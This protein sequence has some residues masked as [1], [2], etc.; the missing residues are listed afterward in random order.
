MLLDICFIDDTI[1]A[2]GDEFIDDTKMLNQAN[3]KYL[4]LKKDWHEKDVQHLVHVVLENQAE[5]NV[6]AFTHPSFYLNSLETEGYRPDIVIYD[7]EYAGGSEDSASM[8]M[9]ILEASYSVV[10]IYS[11]A[12]HKDQIDAALGDSR[13]KPY[14]KRRLAVLMKDETNSQTLLLEKAKTLYEESFAFRFGGALRHACLKALEKVLVAFGKHHKD[15]VR[16]LVREEDTI[17]SDVRAVLNEKIRNCLL[18]DKGLVSTLV[19]EG[20]LDHREANE[21][22]S[23]LCGRIFDLIN[24][25]KLDLNLFRSDPGSEEGDINES[26]ILWS[27]RLYFQPSDSV[28]RKGDI[29]QNNDLKK[30]FL[31]I[32]ADCDLARFWSKNH[33]YINLIPLF[34]IDEA[35][36]EIEHRLR[37]TRND[38]QVKRLIKNLNVDSFTGKI[39]EMVEGPFILPFVSINEELSNFI[40]FPKEIS[41]A[42]IPPPEIANGKDETDRKSRGLSYENWLNVVRIATISEPFL[43]PIVLHCISAVSGYGTPNYPPIVKKAISEGILKSLG[44]EQ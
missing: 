25:A 27:Y 7:W 31:V 5:W 12:D 19:D 43:T 16:K 40:G 44:Q 15:F 13:F 30:Y 1:P 38:G 26:K 22:L 42:Y 8:L 18:E 29:I 17:D 39:N 33:G 24:A 14:L 35:K 4:N 6:S 23:I 32:T 20:G 2:G 28:V 21:L 41:S 10:Y 9:E 37:L 3:L 34:N 36:D 11:G